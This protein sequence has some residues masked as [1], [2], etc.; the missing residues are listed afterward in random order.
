ML[1]TATKFKVALLLGL[2]AASSGTTPSEAFA[3]Q[4][5]PAGC[6]VC[7]ATGCPSDAAKV[8]MCGDYCGGVTWVGA[9][10]QGNCLDTQMTIFSCGVPY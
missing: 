3:E 9:C 2:F 4:A 5:G 1:T 6:S 7:S 8:V 10:T